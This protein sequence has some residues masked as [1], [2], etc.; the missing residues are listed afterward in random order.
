MEF[1]RKETGG[2]LSIAFGVIL[3]FIIMII[4]L[5]TGRLAIF[6]VLLAILFFWNGIFVYKEKFILNKDFIEFKIAPLRKK[7]RLYYSNI[8]SIF[9]KSPKKVFLI[10]KSNND[11]ETRIRFPISD[12]HKEDQTLLKNELNKRII[13]YRS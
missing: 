7:N 8:I 9:E 11:I 2:F 13:A 6:G 10:I 12:L 1:K 5:L 3:F 4:F